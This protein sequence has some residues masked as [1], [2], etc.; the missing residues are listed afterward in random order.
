MCVCVFDIYDLI[1]KNITSTFRRRC[2]RADRKHENKS[3]QGPL[4]AEAKTV[5]TKLNDGQLIM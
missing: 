3:H 5:T 2:L 1:A 4:T